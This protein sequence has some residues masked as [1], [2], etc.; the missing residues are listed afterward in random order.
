MI[1]R[2]RDLDHVH[3]HQFGPQSDVADGSEQIGRLHPAGFRRPGSGSEAGIEDIDVDRQIDE[4]GA[5]ECLLE[6][7]EARL[8]QVLLPVSAW[9]SK[10]TRPT[11]PRP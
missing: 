8:P 4:L 10:W 3:S 7:C 6:A 1:V 2:R 11:L 9:A 5:I